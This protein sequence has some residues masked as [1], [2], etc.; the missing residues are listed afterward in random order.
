MVALPNRVILLIK[1]IPFGYLELSTGLLVRRKNQQKGM[2]LH[3]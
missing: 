2:V 3:E 1:Q